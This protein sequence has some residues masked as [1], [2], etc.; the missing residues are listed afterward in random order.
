MDTVKKA[1]VETQKDVNDYQK[2]LAFDAALEE[3]AL[4]QDG[5]VANQRHRFQQRWMSWILSVVVFFYFF[6]NPL[7]EAPEWCLK[8]YRKHDLPSTKW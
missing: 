1:I 8:Y 2:E 4:V 5:P 6:F 3:K 7:F